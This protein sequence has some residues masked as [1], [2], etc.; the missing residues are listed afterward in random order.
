MLT[1]IIPFDPD[2][3][4]Q[5]SYYH[6]R[7]VQRRLPKP[8]TVGRLA[9]H[10][11]EKQQQSEERAHTLS[12]HTVSVLVMNSPLL[13]QLFKPQVGGGVTIWP[14]AFNCSCIFMTC[15]STLS[16][17]T[18]DDKIS[19]ARSNTRTVLF[20]VLGACLRLVLYLSS[21]SKAHRNFWSV[22]P[23]PLLRGHFF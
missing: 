13:P 9:Q 20:F 18:K 7:Y 19:Q 14:S 16:L 21:L 22:A 5:G 12:L 6:I 4:L 17:L 15:Y 23:R 3:T 10:P 8:Q 2:K 1:H 11:W